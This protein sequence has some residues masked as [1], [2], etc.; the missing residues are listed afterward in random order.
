MEF[1]RA[2]ALVWPVYRG[3]SSNL[4]PATSFGDPKF[5]RRRSYAIRL[6]QDDPRLTVLLQRS[7]LVSRPVVADW[8]QQEVV[9]A[10]NWWRCLRLSVSFG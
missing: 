3:F 5:D 10:Q 4:Y 7:I 6:M 2:D 8:F 1:G 9:N